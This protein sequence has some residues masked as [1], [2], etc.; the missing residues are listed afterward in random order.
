MSE[1]KG[2]TI[3]LIYD[4]NT[5]RCCEI[6]YTPKKWAR[7]TCREFRSFKGN[8]RILNV[9]NSNNTF[10]EDYEGPV[11]LYGTNKRINTNTIGIQYENG[12][13]PREQYRKQGRWRT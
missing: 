1:K 10:Y 13:D 9:D 3:Q 6:E 11:Y 8:R 2:N 4:F 12:I 5:A 7:V